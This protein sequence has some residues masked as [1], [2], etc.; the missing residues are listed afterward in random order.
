MLIKSAQHK[1]AVIAITEV[2]PKHRWHSNKNEFQLEGYNMFS[3]DLDSA[4]TRGVLIYVDEH[5]HSSK[6]KLES[7][8]N[9]NIFVRV[10]S[11]I[12]IGNIY[13]SPNS[14]AENDKELCDLMLLLSKQ[15]VNFI[16]VGDFNFNDIDLKKV[17]FSV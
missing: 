1:P 17:V 9:E 13:R 10:K 7:K 11:D 8:F 16:I 2:K 6:I 14:S 5:L 12:V 15:F 3:N 4:K